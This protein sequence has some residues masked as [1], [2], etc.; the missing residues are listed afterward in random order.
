MRVETLIKMEAVQ[1]HC[2][3]DNDDD[4]D[5]RDGDGDDG[6][7]RD[8]LIKLKMPSLEDATWAHREAQRAGC[9]HGTG[10]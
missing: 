10:I 6:G 4:K 2:G 7:R 1:L 9:G 3:H 8:F 5:D